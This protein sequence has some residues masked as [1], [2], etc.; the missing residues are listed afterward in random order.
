LRRS[1][2]SRYTAE[3]VAGGAVQVAAAAVAA[4][5]G[6]LEVLTPGQLP[7]GGL[8]RAPLPVG[9]VVVLPV[10]VRSLGQSPVLAPRPVR[11]RLE[12][13]DRGGEPG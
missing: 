10:H 12:H 9:A 2:P 7:G 6:L 11:A 1:G 5:V 3:Q 13:A 4:E 8:Q